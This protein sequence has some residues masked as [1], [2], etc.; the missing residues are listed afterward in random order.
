MSATAENSMGGI[1]AEMIE[2]MKKK[3]KW[4]LTL[5]ALSIIIGIAAIAVPRV[6]TLATELLIGWVLLFTGIVQVVHSFYSKGW[7]N[8]FYRAVGALLYIVAGVLLLNYP[9]QGVIAL[10]AL[11]A[12]VFVIEGVFKIVVAVRNSQMV[13]R[14]WLTLNGVVAIMLG[15]FIWMK[16]PFD[17]AWAVGLLVGINLIFGGITMVSMAQGVRKQ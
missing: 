15:F 9:I 4:F 10:T 8:F 7:G 2:E 6:A 3:W 5:G 1:Q 16:L 17:A 11:V 14:E 12:I 13:G